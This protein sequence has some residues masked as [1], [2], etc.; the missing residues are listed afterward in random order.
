MSVTAIIDNTSRV[1]QQEVEKRNTINATHRF[2]KIVLFD[3]NISNI[4]LKQALH[5]IEHNIPTY[6]ANTVSFVNAHC[7]NVAYQNLEYKSVLNQSDIILPDGI[8]VKMA[9]R[10]FGNEL[11]ANLN[12][13]DLFP[14]LCKLAV[15][16]K[17]PLFL[18]GGANGITDKVAAEMKQRYPGLIIAGTHHGFIDDDES[19]CKI[20]RNSGAKLILVGMG[21]PKQE[22]WINRNQKYLTGLIFGVG[23]L[24]DYYS[25]NIPRAPEFVRK[26]SMEWLW[27]LY[28]EPTR[29]FKRYVLGNPLFI[30][31]IVRSYIEQNR[32]SDICVKPNPIIEP[33]R[34]LLYK[35]RLGYRRYCHQTGK[36][37]VDIVLSGLGMI[38][39]SPLF[40]FTTCAIRLESSGAAL[41]TQVRVGQFG[42][43]FNIYKFRSMYLDAEERKKKLQQQNEMSGGV[44]FKMKNDPRITRVGKIIRKLSIDELP[45]LWNVFIGDMSLVGPRPPLPV[46]VSEY[47]LN[48]R[49]RLDVKPG[50]TCI[51]Q[52]SGRSLIPFKQQVEMDIRY[53]KIRSLLTD[54][55][56]LTLTLPAV[57]LGK[58][59][60]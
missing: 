14:H 54:I 15:K 10:I 53:I 34:K 18:L 24:F 2:D 55:K 20:I 17:L 51:W 41:F 8:G 9:A 58:G 22:I 44:I 33:I 4:S 16:N 46:E 27:R 30:Y 45:Q 13:T 35:T 37:V 28:Q 19:I 31:R 42:K 32:E 50:I 49:N 6:S 39:L 7:L 25:G 47:T 40:L 11:R 52:I 57:I 43:E 29:L 26:L 60:Y 3:I 56:I 59:A 1:K 48:D 21:V 12:G 5:W 23:G 36:R 38:A